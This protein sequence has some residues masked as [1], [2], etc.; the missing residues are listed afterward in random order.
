MLKEQHRFVNNNNAYNTGKNNFHFGNYDLVRR[1]DVG[2]MG[3]VYLAHQRTAF[4]REV[5]VKIIRS[6]L[7]HDMT[8]RR[9]F[10]REAEVS[11]HLKHEHILPLV[12][13][14][15]EQGRLFLV[16]PYIEGGTL[17]KRLQN[18]PLSLSEIHQLFSA[19]VRAVVYIHKRGVIHRDLKPSNILLDRE[20]GGDQIYV[21]LIDFGI[22]SIQGTTASPPLT[23]AGNELGTVAYMAPERLSGI[24]APS[25]DIYSLGIILY[26]MLTDDLPSEGELLSILHPF[27]YV[28]ERCTLANPEDRFASAD[29]LL[30]AFEQAYKTFAASAR[31]QSVVTPETLNQNNFPT[32]KY[33][34][35]A[36][37]ENEVLQKASL[38][39]HAEIVLPEAP[40]AMNGASPVRTFNP[41]DYGAPTTQLDP[42]QLS[43]KQKLVEV[44]PIHTSSRLRRRKR[45]LVGFISLA[46]VALLVVTAAIG[47]FVFQATISANATVSPQVHPL[48]KVFTVFAR[49]TQQDINVNSASIHASVATANATGSKTSPAIGQ[50]CTPFIGCIPIG[51]S[52]DVDGL[53]GQTRSDLR[54]QLDQELQAKVRADGGTEV[55]GIRYG[56]GPLSSNPTTDQAGRTVNVVSLTEQASVEYIKPSDLRSLVR[57][58]L[59]QQMN[60]QFAGNYML[61]DRFTQMGQP[62][63]QDVD[64]NGVITIQ[65]AAGGVAK[66][67]ISDDQLR[68]MT[69]HLTGLKLEAAKLFLAQQQ[70]VDPKTITI[71]ISYGDTI[72]SNVLQIHLMLVDPNTT[73]L[74]TVQLPQVG[75]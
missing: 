1:I 48:S 6:D 29:D 46:M 16:T 27:D 13:F 58:L 56:D 3:E 21:R 57:L 30:D 55:G 20:E 66:S 31:T 71:R 42:A 47:F 60:K 67:Q 34:T 65:V 17:A 33:A 70:G 22:A 24:A 26:E 18:E 43:Q 14:G 45:S 35:A 36:H 15:E 68:S 39:Q 52:F 28:V 74:P 72:P 25:N 8:A 62:V 32:P 5:A 53:V 64:G 12:E 23:R 49:P 63:V 59:I 7:V 2:G 54:A 37:T 41:E 69:E 61:I 40:L 11:A 38:Q 10:L 50:I 9:R 51:G 4:G 73:N 19:L 75:A 44:V